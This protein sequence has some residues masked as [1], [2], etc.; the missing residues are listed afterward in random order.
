MRHFIFI[1]FPIFFVLFFTGCDNLP[2]DFPKLYPVTL[3]ITQEGTPLA[4]ADILLYSVDNPQARWLISGKTDQNGQVE[5]GTFATTQIRKKGVPEGPFKVTV[6]KSI[7]D[8]TPELSDMPS[9]AEMKAWRN[10]MIQLKPM[11]HHFI[12]K[13]YT[14][15]NS[16]PL[17]ITIETKSN[18]FSLDVGKK[19]DWTTPIMF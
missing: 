5:L 6:Y 10:K 14:E 12:E 16:T 19:V 17:Q 11:W 3:I 2:K 1:S 18:K 9:D 7:A 15:P 4:D 8:K 13:Q